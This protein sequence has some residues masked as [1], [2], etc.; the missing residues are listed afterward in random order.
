MDQIQNAPV[1]ESSDAPV[2]E[3]VVETPQVEAKTEETIS[4]V[5]GTKETPKAKEP[6]TVPEAV[7]LEQKR[8][9]KALKKMIEDGATKKEVAADIKSLAEKHNIDE[10]FLNEFVATVKESS[11]AEFEA[12]LA[13][14]LA[15]LQERERGEK[16]EKAFD[17]AF[18]R[19]LNDAPEYEGIVNREVIKALSLDPK[20]ANKTFNQLID[21][22]F[23][24]L[25]TG[26]KTIDYSSG[27]NRSDGATV[28]M[29]K[30]KSDGEYFK[31][32]MADPVLKKQY[33]EGI[34]GR[35]AS[36]L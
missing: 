32:V 15:P 35:L 24:H 13:S 8:E 3:A 10:E 28:D 31:K 36:M 1:S 34:D 26:K 33:N 6:K 11:K 30:A 18:K 9:L 16:I 29:A 12:E 5:L 19:A 23:G 2:T 21:E 17:K 25:V 14:K 20:N 27:S 7:F 22:S 4:E